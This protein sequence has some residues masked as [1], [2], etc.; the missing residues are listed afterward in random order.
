MAPNAEDHD[1]NLL[2]RNRERLGRGHP[3]AT[4]CCT[5]VGLGFSSFELVFGY[6]VRGPLKLVKEKLL[7][8]NNESINLLQYVSDF[9][10]KLFRA[11][12][13]A[14]ANLSSS[15]KF[16]KK[17][18]DVDAVERSFKPGQKVLALLPVPS[19]PLNSRFFR[20]YVIQKKI[21]CSSDVSK[22]RIRV[23]YQRIL[24]IRV[25]QYAHIRTYMSF[26]YAFS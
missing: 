24:R 9:R 12:E 4:V 18:Y 20:P 26:C 14:R 10:T 16:M 25:F 5:R 6:T 8:S 22:L 19:N 23:L 15:Q 1:E 11:C 21:Q 2:L 3:F 7:S 13:L 17:K